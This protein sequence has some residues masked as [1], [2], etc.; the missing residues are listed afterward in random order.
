M[1]KSP[2]SA[3]SDGRDWPFHPVLFD[4]KGQRSL[5]NGT[6]GKPLQTLHKI[7]PAAVLI[8]QKVLS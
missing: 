8:L 1:K 3:L 2:S 5:G 4:H 7:Y 6:V